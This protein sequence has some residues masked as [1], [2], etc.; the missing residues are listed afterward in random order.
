VKVDRWEL[1][2]LRHSVSKARVL[3]LQ[4]QAAW[5]LFEMNVATQ[6]KTG[7][8]QKTLHEFKGYW[9]NV[10]FLTCFFCIF[11]TYRRLIL[12]HYDIAY[13]EYGVSLIKALILAKIMLVG[14]ALRL[15]R[16]FADQPLMIPTLYRAFFFTFFVSIIGVM[17]S[18][19]R[20]FWGGKGFAEAFSQLLSIFTYEWFA[21]TLMIFF[22]F[23]PFFAVR[24]LGRVL[25]PG[26]ISRLF[27]FRKTEQ[28]DGQ[29]AKP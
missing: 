28:R 1:S 20:S 6:E 2:Q 22:V 19:I 3:P 11:T 9:F 12:A 13:D 16:K 26:E 7:W 23:I 24:E 25:P 10:F 21:Q 29:I 27:F 14:E 17:E 4:S 18:L 15:G 5:E 8:K